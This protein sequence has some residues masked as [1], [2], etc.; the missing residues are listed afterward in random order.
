MFDISIKDGA[1]TKST[2]ASTFLTK[3]YYG[4]QVWQFATTPPVPDVTSPA[5]Q[6]GDKVLLALHSAQFGVELWVRAACDGCGVG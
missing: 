4:T 2:M 5:V 3:P 6:Y 1:V